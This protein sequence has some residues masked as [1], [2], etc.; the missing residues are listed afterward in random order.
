MGNS[1]G[2]SVPRTQNGGT[3]SCLIKMLQPHE[4]LKNLVVLHDIITQSYLTAVT[5]IRLYSADMYTFAMISHCSHSVY[6]EHFH[7]SLLITQTLLPHH[8]VCEQNF[9]DSKDQSSYP[10]LGK[11]RSWYDY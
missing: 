2:G 8:E 9:R 10:F 1:C 11:S 6:T 3:I 4:K 7:P 5:G